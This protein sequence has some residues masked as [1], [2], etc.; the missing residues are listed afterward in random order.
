MFQG[1]L[2]QVQDESLFPMYATLVLDEKFFPTMVHYHLSKENS[3][4]APDSM[5]AKA[6]IV[7]IYHVY[8][9]EEHRY[10]TVSVS[11]L[12]KS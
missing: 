7:E 6:F 9:G 8:P 1:C 10:T 2:I 4:V 12:V 5:R 11:S 3:V